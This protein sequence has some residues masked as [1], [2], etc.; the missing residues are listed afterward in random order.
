[1]KYVLITI[2]YQYVSIHSWIRL[3]LQFCNIFIFRSR[4]TAL[5]SRAMTSPARTTSGR[6]TRTSVT[7]WCSCG[8]RPTTRSRTWWPTSTASTSTTSPSRTSCRATSS[9]SV[10]SLSSMIERCRLW[11]ERYSRRILYCESDVWFMVGVL[12]CVCGTAR[13]ILEYFY[14]CILIWMLQM[15]QVWYAA[16][17]AHKI[18]AAL[19]PVLEK[20]VEGM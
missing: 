15:L 12:I 19:H 5:R 18:G 9:R 10:T 8:R 6:W 1:M 2:K 7:G 13:V 16:H 20:P 14:G 4:L 3:F 17:Y 11:S